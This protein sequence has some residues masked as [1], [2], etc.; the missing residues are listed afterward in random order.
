MRIVILESAQAVSHR[1]A[2]I[3]CELLND[4]PNAV[5]GL[6]TG[7]TPLA[8]YDELVVRYNQQE[9]SFAQAT[10]FNLDEYVDMSPE[11]AQSYHTFMRENL[12]RHIDI[13]ASNCHLPDGASDNHWRA[14]EHY[15]QLI[16]QA[17][18]I[19]LQLLG[20]GT[21]GHI[22]FNEPGSSLASRTRLKALT[23]QTRRDNA[24]FFDSLEDVPR[25]AITMG[26]GTI[27]E[28]HD[29]VLLAT[30]AG[31]AGAVR[32]FVEGP[33]TAQVPASAL[34]MHPNVTVLLD[35][36]AASWLVRTDYYR[37]VEAVQRSLET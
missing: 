3:M 10:S 30:G 1:A 26:I 16:D 5:L 6:A 8:T 11:H 18:G 24:R 20:I 4:K 32:A 22:A 34:Q 14:C 9:V 17:G 25:L 21:D 36:D 12:F 23:E 28:A 35:E 7:G 19:D 13:D 29:I 33:V 37:Q 31:K 27:L 2:D 15:E